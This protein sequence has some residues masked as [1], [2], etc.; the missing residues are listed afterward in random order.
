MNDLQQEPIAII[1]LGC[2]FPGAKTP[3]EFWQ[4]LCEGRSAVGRIPESRWAIDQLYDADPTITGPL[5][6]C[7][8]GFLDNID[9]FDWRA[10]RLSP[11][12]VKYMD[13]QHRLLLE[14]AWEALEDAGL[15]LETV[16]RTSTAV[17]QGVS[18]N[19]Y[20][21]L[22]TR[23]WSKLNGYTV[24]GNDLAFTANRLSYCFDL[25]GPSV[26]IA[27]A[28]AASLVAVHYACQSLRLGEA[29]IA[30]AGGVIL[31]ISP[32]ISIMLSRAGLLSPEGKCKTLDAT[33]DGFVRGEGAGIVVLKPL[34]K[35]N[36]SDRIYALLVG[37]AVNHNGQ[38]EWIMA[39]NQASQISAIQQACARAGV[40]PAAIDYV[41]LH[42]TGLPKGDPIEAKAVGEA[43]GTVAGRVSP[44]CI[45]SVK[46][47]LGHLEAAAGIASLIKVAL[48][49]YHQKLPPTLNL[50]QIHPDI[51]L[52]ALGLVAQ[53]QLTPWP[54]KTEAHLAGVTAVS[55]AGINA[56]VILREFVDA[57]VDTLA[58]SQPL[59][60]VYLL[61]LSAHSPTALLQY[62]TDIKDYLLGASSQTIELRDICYTASVRRSHH[63][64]RA[65]IVGNSRQS[66]VQAL[67]SYQ[68]DQ[69]HDFKPSKSPPKL[70]F[71]LPDH[72]PSGWQLDRLCL[73]NWEVFQTALET[74]DQVCLQAVHCSVLPSDASTAAISPSSESDVDIAK[75]ELMALQIALAAV[76]QS[77]GIT[78][79]TYIGDGVGEIVALHLVGK[80]SLESAILTVVN[81]YKTSSF[82]K[83]T[84]LPTFCPGI[85]EFLVANDYQVFIELAPQPV[86]LDAIADTLQQNQQ[87]P[88]WLP[89]LVCSEPA[90]VSM[91]QCLSKLYILGY[92]INWQQLYSNNCHCV[93]LPTYPWQRERLWLEWLNPDAIS[94]SPNQMGEQFENQIPVEI[95]QRGTT[96]ENEKELGRKSWDQ[97]AAIK[98][99][100]KLSEPIATSNGSSL[101]APKSAAQTVYHLP[102]GERQH[103]LAT[104]LIDQV[105]S[106]LGRCANELDPQVPLNQ[107]GLDSISAMELKHRIE[108]S[109]DITIPIS[110]FLGGEKVDKIVT[111]TIVPQ[112]ELDQK[113]DISK[114]Q[115]SSE[116]FNS[117]D[118]ED[119]KI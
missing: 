74:F 35:V 109:L 64:Y 22:Q 14:V 6:S 76:L 103:W 52:G 25:K 29:E 112:I 116:N 28:C 62:I 53:T 96:E 101:V 63:P 27:Q 11:R 3:Q 50:K 111:T 119:F 54:T 85:S 97:G 12:E 110:K 9:Q 84:E 79:D 7:W 69:G 81:N 48:A 88:Y 82:Q 104:Y 39:A 61:P 67:V 108:N 31:M 33:A 49:Q 10:L 91:F 66:L 68:D 45:G 44:C 4:L 59:E 70:V 115:F 93:S 8:G 30:I 17:F 114:P 24:T 87:D 5:A 51:S 13:P 89:T 78:P 46:T 1:G 34:S 16:A 107:L 65:A 86:L 83:D 41:E 58:I 23:D 26:T 19:D 40:A 72:V 42:G 75:L 43:M 15:P 92:T 90:S 113:T 57:N 94:M 32:D 80:L 118:W 60:Q 56:H 36:P 2:R 37:S 21:R 73:A 98:L 55:M 38:N 105:A 106:V 47:N 18:S 100:G 102:L 20:F 117:K 77:W 95:K 71:L 99:R